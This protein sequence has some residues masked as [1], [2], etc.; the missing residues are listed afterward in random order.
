M[1]N[2]EI[3]TIEGYIKENDNTTDQ[4][5]ILEEIKDYMSK[6]IYFITKEMESKIP[7]FLSYLRNTENEIL[8]KLKVIKYFMSLIK[9]IPYN[10]DLILAKKLNDKEE[11]MNLYEILINEY[12]FTDESEKD[13]IQLLKDI[14]MLIF[15]KLSL[16]K[17]IYRYMFSYVSTFLNDK[18]QMSLL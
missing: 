2:P 7:S 13:Y 5:N 18:N 3:K 10:L 8:N 12:I 17:D 6:G 15:R 16:N 11:S 14:I 4:N 9:N 1:E